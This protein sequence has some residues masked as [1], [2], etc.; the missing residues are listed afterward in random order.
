VAIHTNADSKLY[1]SPTSV[2]VD[3]I[4]A[5]DDAAAVTFFEGINDWIEVEEVEDLGE[6]GDT[7]ESITFTALANARVRKLK[8]PRDAGTQTIAVGRDPLDDGQEA[9]IAAEKTKFDFPVKIVLADARTANYSNS[10]LYYA[11]MVQGAPTNLGNV[12]NV[13]RRTFTVGI[14]TAIWEV[15][16]EVLAAPTNTLEPSIAGVLDEA[17]VLTAIEGVWTGNPTFTY[18]WNRDGTPIAGATAKTY[19]IVAGDVG[20]GL[21]VTVTGTNGAG[22]ASATSATTADVPA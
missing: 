8:G 14:N 3:T 1:I 17:E 22:N 15:V 6:L 7:S 4:N 12:S 20:T 19:T 18:V 21:S 9:F 13:V 16:S 10:I 5:M 2:S 11:G